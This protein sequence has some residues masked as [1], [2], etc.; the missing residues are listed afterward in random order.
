MKSTE[1]EFVHS[2]QGRNTV[3]FENRNYEGLCCKLNHSTKERMDRISN[4][5]REQLH[6]LLIAVM[7]IV[8]Y[9]IQTD[10]L[11]QKIKIEKNM[12]K[13]DFLM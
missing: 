7:E 3:N 6:I 5:R 8:Y 11:K 2:T 1:I 4:G 12:E 10:L 9:F 13:K